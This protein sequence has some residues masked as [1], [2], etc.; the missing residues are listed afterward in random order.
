VLAACALFT[1]ALAVPALAVLN[2]NSGAAGVMRYGFWAAMPF[3]FALLVRLAERP[4]WPAALVAALGVVQAAAMAS[5]LSYSYV[6]FSPIARTLLERAPNLYHPEPEIFAERNGRNDDYIQPDRVYVYKVDGRPVKTLVNVANQRADL[7]LCGTGGTLATDNRYVES[8]RGW[9]YLDGPAR[10]VNGGSPN[11]SYAAEQ[12][13]AGVGISL[14]SG[15]SGVERSG[16][17]WDGVW[18]DGARSRLVLETAGLNPQTL[19]LSGQYLD[20][21]R[22]THVIVNG[23]DL[24]WHQLNQEGPLA[25]PAGARAAATLEVQL[26]HEAP[27]SPGPLDG[28]KLAFFLNQVTLRG[29]VATAAQSR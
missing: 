10:C 7:L 15:W 6:E 21:N 24:G 1:L 12:F 19:A 9:R 17:A 8:A 27:H 22:R 13:A 20:G 3:V 25:L 29:A 16:G 4:R 2:W 5:A 14:A 11:R 23:E 26:E 28:R 18:S